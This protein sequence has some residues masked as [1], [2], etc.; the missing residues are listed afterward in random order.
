MGVDMSANHAQG[1]TKPFCR[2]GLAQ[3]SR[4]QRDIFV[5]SNGPLH[6][7]MAVIE[8]EWASSRIAGKAHSSI[9]DLP[10]VEVIDG[11]L[12]SVAA[13]YDN[14]MAYSTRLAETAARLSG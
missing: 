12:V 13:W 4:S 9:I 6:G 8:N 1:H 7:V 14:E 2:A 10:L 5:V 11:T 3:Q